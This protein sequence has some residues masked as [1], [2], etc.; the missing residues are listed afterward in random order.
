MARFQKLPGCFRTRQSI[1][2]AFGILR[3]QKEN[4]DYFEWKGAVPHWPMGFLQ[5]LA[6]SHAGGVKTQSHPRHVFVP[7]KGVTAGD[8][9]AFPL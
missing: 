5:E 4:R 1:L 2:P 6:G 7:T 9:R 8:V 3:R